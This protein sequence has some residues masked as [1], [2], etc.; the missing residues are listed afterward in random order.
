MAQSAFAIFFLLSLAAALSTLWRLAVHNT[1]RVI[2][3]LFG[4]QEFTEAAHLTR[5]EV[6]ATADVPRI[7]DRLRWAYPANLAPVLRV[8]RAWAFERSSRV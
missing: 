3:T 6:C 1:P 4:T 5:V 8:P 2:R 7:A